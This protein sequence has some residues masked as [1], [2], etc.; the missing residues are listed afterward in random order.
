[1][2]RGGHDV[3]ASADV[4]DR[5]SASMPGTP[6][7]RPEVSMTNNTQVLV[8]TSAQMIWSTIE[9][10]YRRDQMITRDLVAS[11]TGLKLMIVD[12][13]LKRMIEDGRLRRLRRGVFAPT[14]VMYEPRP[15][16]MKMMP[17]GMS[18][19]EIG[20]LCVDLWPA[21][22]RML[23]SRLVGDAVQY[24]NIQAGQETNF[25]ANTA[26]EELKKFRRSQREG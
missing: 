11:L 26:W 24:S 23:A 7:F 13:T 21:E 16:S 17:G 10:L 15:V 5:S 3:G 6:H 14:N 9:D 12:D 1:M 4:S 19:M 2:L 20:D 22:R 25:L 8:P 18:K